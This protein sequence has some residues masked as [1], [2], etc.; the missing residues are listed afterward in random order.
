MPERA[1]APVDPEQAARAA[2]TRGD[3]AAAAQAWLA[4]ASGSAS[5]ARE[6]YQL[7]AAAAWL[8]A[9]DPANS[10]AV[11]AQAD[12]ATLG[13]ALI[14]RKQIL[15]ARLALARDDP[16]GAADALAPTRL[17]D[18]PPALMAER[19]GLLAQVPAGAAA[20]GQSVAGGDFV[21]VL[22]PYGDE[23]EAAAQAIT[24]GLVAARLG[25]PS[26]PSLRF[27][28]SGDDAVASYR[29]AVAD[30]AAVV[31]GPLQKAEVRALAAMPLA[32]PTL[33][34]NNPART[35]G[36]INLYRLSLDPADEAAAGARWLTAAGYRRVAMLYVDDPW[37][38]RLR[39]LYRQA[40]EA[41]GGQL[42]G[43][44]PFD[45]GDTDF[46][47]ALRSLFA[48]RLASADP[49]IATE[50]G[51]QAL[52]VI[53]A[54]ADA[55]QIMPQLE[56]V[57]LFDLPVL[58]TS[59]LWNGNPNRAAD[60]DLGNLVFCDSPWAL[61]SRTDA[62]SPGPLAA[63]TRV[64]PLLERSPPRLAALGADAYALGRLLWQGR[65]VDA[66]PDGLTGALAMDVDGTLRRQVLDCARFSGGVPV[67][68][69]RGSFP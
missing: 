11:L 17:L 7:H 54:G 25:D 36:Q 15:L 9:G 40:L 38:R 28:S 4:L 48:D 55:R 18:L 16:A 24:A 64:W 29:R 35:A 60:A 22:L 61:E 51:P 34:L 2:E 49:V 66:L 42:V 46:A 21:A 57:G 12:V 69:T 3:Y 30:G 68:M 58:G 10:Q 53:A 44:V 59:R 33:A 26:G 65:S 20:P 8:A 27:Y 47:P 14:A 56:Y 62:G 1:A 19:D 31:I 32:R 6:A 50:S 52:I 41:Q 39:T 23:L 5:P 43:A 67:V 37:G 13:D 45:A 63:A